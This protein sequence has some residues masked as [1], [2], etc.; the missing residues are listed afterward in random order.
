M[1]EGGPLFRKLCQKGQGKKRKPK[2]E[3]ESIGLML[4]W[5]VKKSQRSVKL[6]R[7]AGEFYRGYN[8]QSQPSA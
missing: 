3:H 7:R 2:G 8:P 1:S 4:I 6:R 5:R